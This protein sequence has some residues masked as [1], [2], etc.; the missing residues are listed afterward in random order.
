MKDATFSEANDA[1]YAGRPFSV[2]LEFHGRNPENVSGRSDKF[3]LIEREVAHGLIRIRYGKTGSYGTVTAEVI[4]AYEAFNRLYDKQAK[5]YQ[6]TECLIRKPKV[7]SLDGLFGKIRAID[8]DPEAR[9]YVARDESGAILCH[10]PPHTAAEILR[11][12]EIA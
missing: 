8:L 10:L 9:H 1:A 11:N 4:S 2:K 5:G 6:I 3:W 7:S 12:Y